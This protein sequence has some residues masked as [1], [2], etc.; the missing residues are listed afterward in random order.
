ME[1]RRYFGNLH[2]VS[3]AAPPAVILAFGNELVSDLH[4]LNDFAHIY[5]YEYRRSLTIEFQ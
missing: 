4:T 2:Q 3:P 5:N 1:I